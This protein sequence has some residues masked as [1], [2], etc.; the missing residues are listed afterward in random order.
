MRS[1][2]AT[3]QLLVLACLVVL[4]DVLHAIPR[5]AARYQQNCNLCHMN[6]T[7]GGMRSLYASTFL[8]PT[9]MALFPWKDEQLDKIRPDLTESVS[10]GTDIRMVHHYANKARPTPENNFFQMQGDVYL[11]FQMGPQFSA[12]L[13]RGQSSTLELF[14][15]AYVLP[16][17]GYLK[18]GRFT[19]AFGWKFADHRQ[20]VRQRLFF[21]PPNQTDVGLE[22]GFFPGRYSLVLASVNGSG[23]IPADTDAIL[24]YTARGSARLRVRAVAFELGGS[25]WR[26]SERRGLRLAGGPFGYVNIG[27]FTW[28]WEVD[29]SKLRPLESAS[30]TQVVT[31]H[32]FSWQVVQGMDV[33]GAY[34]FHDPN[35]T[36]P[37]GTRSRYSVGVETLV[38]PFFKF[39]AMAHRYL[40][41][42]GTDVRE[43]SYTQSEVIFH[44]LY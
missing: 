28:L 25:Y 32:E 31:S 39:R 33:L 36:S 12:Y 9:E 11:N 1:A 44:V 20:F 22:V 3:A 14:G 21:E 38:R 13:D 35:V 15:L 16:K 29:W 2:A 6:P 10:I 5:Y 17:N 41:V 18:F 43:N 27:P 7:G 23:G 26:N 4:P 34:N 30:T 24:A 8:V 42:L 37:T 40:N 19:P